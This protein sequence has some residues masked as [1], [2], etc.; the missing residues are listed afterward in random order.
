[1]PFNRIAR[2]RYPELRDLTNLVTVWNDLIR[3]LEFRDS[4]P[5]DSVQRNGT[6]VV[7]SSDYQIKGFEGF[8][9]ADTGAGTVN[10]YLPRASEVPSR[11]ISFKK[12]SSPHSLIVNAFGS[13]TIDG[14]STL[15]LN[16][17]NSVDTLRSSGEN[18]YIV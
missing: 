14:V 16:S 4:T 13:E 6:N 8:I 7:I 1:M 9:L 18:W 2:P 11:L 10:V 5:I 3:A 12:I 17:I 15:T